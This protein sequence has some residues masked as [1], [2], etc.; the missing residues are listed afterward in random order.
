MIKKETRMENIGDTKDT[1]RNR[2]FGLIKRWLPELTG[3]IL[4]GIGGY[5]YYIKV[6]CS[7]GACP[8]TSNPWM[9][10]IW[11]SITGYLIGSFFNSKNNKIKKS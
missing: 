1:L 7:S 10:I 8:I 3:L 2:L 9:T 5:I 4:G 11:G 6:G